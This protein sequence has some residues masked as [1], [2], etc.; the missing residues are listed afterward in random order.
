M[1]KK[2]HCNAINVSAKT[3]DITSQLLP[4]E[5][6]AHFGHSDLGVFAR[7]IKSGKISQTDRLILQ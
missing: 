5:M 6:R 3:G 2:N 1:F 4:Q 7:V